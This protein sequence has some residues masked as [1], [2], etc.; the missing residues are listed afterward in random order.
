MFDVSV[1]I[2]AYNSA[3]CVQDAIASVF[4][5]S[6]R[7]LEVIVVDDGSTDGT[8]E[9]LPRLRNLRL[10]RR[11]RGGP[12]AA[13]NTGLRAARG[14]Y[15][16]F[17]DAD[18]VWEPQ[19]LEARLSLATN[20]PELGLVFADACFCKG[21]QV[22]RPSYLAG[23]VVFRR[24]GTSQPRPGSYIFSRSIAD[25]LMIE[26]FIAT[27]TVLM[28]RDCLE[29]VGLFDESMWIGEDTDMWYRVARRFPVG[30]IDQVAARCRAR[31]ESLTADPEIVARGLV[32][33]A[34]KSLEY[35][36]D[37][38]SPEVCAVLRRRLG[39]YLVELGELHASRGRL[40]AAR[41]CF[42]DGL[43][44]SSARRSSALRL[45][46]TFLGP[47]GRRIGTSLYRF[48]RTGEWT[49]PESWC[50]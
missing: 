42:L 1:V 27:D 23:K 39:R 8:A 4:A 17:L 5:Q 35:Y 41:R 11:P 44:C 30:Y 19:S 38:G 48:L 14:R 6:C 15:V 37:G 9:S 22:V 16:A 13:R 46:A 47:G 25:E 28:H 21:A 18:D 24:V 20:H 49:A 40:G 36:R 3:K 10:L 50:R 32:A 2:P 45:A 34:A 26:P 31:P 33:F 7:S 12:S 43:R 29:E